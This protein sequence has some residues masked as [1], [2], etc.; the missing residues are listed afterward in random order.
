MPCYSPLKGYKDPETGGIKFKK[1]GTEETM[2]VA[3]G[4]CLGCRLDR[5]RMWAA[6]I[7]HE[8][9]LHEHS[10]GNCFITLTYR[11]E[12]ECTED[13]LKEGYHIP[14]DWSLNV[15]H[16]QLFMKRLRKHL[17]GRKVRYYHC[18]E[19]GSVCRHGIDLSKVKCPL[20]HLGRPHYHA[21][22]FNVSFGDL[23]AYATERE[24]TRY[25]SP[26]LESLWKHGFV[27][28][29]EVNFQ[30]A[31]YVARYVMKKITGVEADDHYQN[32]AD[33][34]EIIKVEPEYSTMSNGIGKDWYLRF[35]SDCFPS[36]EVPVPGHGVVPKVPRYYAEMLRQTDEATYEEI[37]E[38]RLNFR[39]ENADQ[40][41]PEALHSK[42]K[43]KKAQ[44][45]NLL[46][47]D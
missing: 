27:D 30:S 44:T 21:I 29:G 41:T 45:R 9:S 16:F 5:S 28:V 46:T 8:A 6:R 35:E 4:Q 32:I 2:E 13:Q 33:D 3:C 23:E 26:T 22:L 38:R 12:E 17:K 36:D 39:N 40:Y 43:V 7:T 25:T 24:Q 14:E 10:H 15:R 47:R 34:G 18:G 20:C 42:Y 31:A 11:P 1:T 19:Y 37:K